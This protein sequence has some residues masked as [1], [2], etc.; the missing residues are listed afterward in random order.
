LFSDSVEIQLSY[1]SIN[2]FIYAQGSTIKH[3][4]HSRRA[5]E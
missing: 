3:W 1:Q 4:L 2:Q 5:V